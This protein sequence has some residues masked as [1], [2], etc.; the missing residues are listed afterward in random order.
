MASVAAPALAD[1][2]EDLGRVAEAHPDDMK[3]CDAFAAAALKQKRYDDAIRHLKITVAR[4]PDYPEGY[5]KLAYAYRAKKEWADAADYY[6]RY[7]ALNPSRSDTY[8][9]LGAALEGLGDSKG[10]IAA[11]QKYVAIEKAPSKQRFVD[12]AWAELSKLSGTEGGV[13]PVVPPPSKPATAT[14]VTNDHVPAAGGGN[15]AAAL[16]A[17]ADDLRAQNKWTEAVPAYKRAIAADPGN[18]DLCND[19]GNTYFA[20]KQY[21]DAAQAFASATQ[22]D[23]SYALGW[24]NQAH[25]LRKAERWR[26]S[27]DAYRQYIKLKPDDPDP[28]YGLGQTLKA[29]GDSASA[30]G[31]FQKYVAMERRP[32]EQKWVEKARAELQALEA[33]QAPAAVHAPSGKIE[34][35]ST[36]DDE[37]REK[38][39]RELK[40]DAV[41]PPSDDDLRLMDPFTRA[42]LHDLKDPFHA[43]AGDDIVDPFERSV[44]ASP[45]A[46][47]LR[48]YGAA[49][50]AYRR[51]LSRHAEEVAQRFD[52][53]V[54]SALATNGGANALRAWNSVPLDD[55]DLSA[56][57]ASVERIRK[58]L[59]APAPAGSTPTSLR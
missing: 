44:A 58:S 55:S 2:L 42:N 10:A 6:R 43:G 37:A 12:E 41:L 52:R 24:Y 7:I 21:S 9:G 59:T 38:L 27:A 29:L 40:R 1:E 28:Y 48:Q 56:A 17:R 57:R 11:Y 47:R 3:A 50:A 23:P 16:R 18:L 45:T 53:G 35:K 51:A 8:F 20:L 14:N 54:A 36:S 39:D 22:R 5:Y 26:D 33:A 19:L 25:A 31:A 34:E 15:D 32:D 13:P 30:I 46:E 4:V 49:L